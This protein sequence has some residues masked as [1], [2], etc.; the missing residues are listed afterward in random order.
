MPVFGVLKYLGTD[1]AI[2]ATALPV[3]YGSKSKHV[4]ILQHKI[5]F[6]VF[7]KIIV[8]FLH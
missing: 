4:A 7:L 1:Q 3:V 8:A 2:Q 6:V 5:T